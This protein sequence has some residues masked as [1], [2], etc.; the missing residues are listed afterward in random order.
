MAFLILNAVVLGGCIVMLLLGAANGPLILL[1]IGALGML[2][3]KV[4]RAY[5]RAQ[6]QEPPPLPK[7]ASTPWTKPTN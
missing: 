1:T 6:R 7:T 2:V 4:G 3:G 5:S